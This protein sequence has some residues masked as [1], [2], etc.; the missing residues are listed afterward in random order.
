MK[1]KH[2]IVE[3]FCNYDKGII[4]EENNHCSEASGKMGIHC[5]GCKN[6]SY[7]Y[8]PSELAYSNEEGIVASIEDW[9]SPRFTKGIEEN[10]LTS[11]EKEFYSEKWH[12]MCK[13]AISEVYDN[14]VNATGIN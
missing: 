11:E 4:P 14:F 1:M 7:T 9:I 5:I 2:L 8:A 12:D 6:F 13:K 10:E 3:G